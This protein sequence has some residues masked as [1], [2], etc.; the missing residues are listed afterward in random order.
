MKSLIK[1]TLR[2]VGL[3]IVVLCIMINSFTN[4]SFAYADELQENNPV[5]YD[6]PISYEDTSIYNDFKEFYNDKFPVVGDE[7][8]FL[9]LNECFYGYDNLYSLYLYTYL[10][11]SIDSIKLLSAK[12]SLTFGFVDNENDVLRADY[13]KLRIFTNTNSI[14]GDSSLNSNNYIGNKLI[15]PYIMETEDGKGLFVKW[16]VD[17]SNNNFIPNNLSVRFYCVSGIESHEDGK[18]NATE[19]GVCEVFKCYEDDSNVLH[20]DR[21]GL[22]GLSVD[23]FHTFYRSGANTF[24]KSTESGWQDQISSC[25]FSL[26]KNIG[27]VGKSNL[28]SVK[29]GFNYA[30][31]TPILI[32]PYEDDYNL[33]LKNLFCDVTEKEE[34]FSFYSGF[35][36]YINL[37]S[38]GPDGFD[39]FYNWQMASNTSKYSDLKVSYKGIKTPTVSSGIECRWNYSYDNGYKYLGWVFY[40]ENLKNYINKDKGVIKDSYKNDYK[41]SEDYRYSKENLEEHYKKYAELVEN[42]VEN[43]RESLFDILGE[44]DLG[45]DINGTT[46]LGTTTDEIYHH[47]LNYLGYKMGFGDE[48]K[49]IIVFGEYGGKDEDVTQNILELTFSNLYQNIQD[50]VN[51]WT[52]VQTWWK[53]LSGVEN[54]HFQTLNPLQKISIYDVN[55]L[56][57]EQFSNRYL[58]DKSEVGTIKKYC[59]DEYSNNRDVWLL[60][61]DCCEY[62]SAPAIYG[63]KEN[64][65]TNGLNQTCV[66]YDKCGYVAR[67]PMYFDWDVLS[68]GFNQDGIS[69]TIPVI[70]SSKNII[71]DIT[72]QEDLDT[73]LFEFF[74]GLAT[75]LLIMFA[76]IILIIVFPPLKFVFKGIFTVIKLLFKVIWSIFKT[77]FKILFY[78]IKLIFGGRKDDS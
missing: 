19:F 41:V 46:Y 78:P 28:C 22:T 27:E 15:T 58:V 55:S 6:K 4:F 35:Y 3:F 73:T 68:F 7:F 53:S 1:N 56:D 47:S 48:N 26:P 12:N 31:T 52:N 49:N 71:H 14:L 2:Y 8:K 43:Y 36:N 13:H 44:K 29:T 63:T 67:Q 75:V 11:F 74:D 23:F 64:V 16:K 17:L 77:I 50:K 40:D 72:A 32:L 39:I 62:Y 69:V 42:N 25:Y 33:A 70:H 30:F 38:L 20:I 65:F 60:R 54:S 18:P 21:S 59:Q 45:V 37:A 9:F 34:I 66:D 24:D 51:F 76:L 57:V 61:Y 5:G 10:P